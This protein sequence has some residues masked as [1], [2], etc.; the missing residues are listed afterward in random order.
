MF[1]IGTDG[2][3]IPEKYPIYIYDRELDRELIEEAFLLMETI[4]K[5]KSISKVLAEFE[6]KQEG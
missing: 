4:K 2:K 6:K 5:Q 3:A 1:R